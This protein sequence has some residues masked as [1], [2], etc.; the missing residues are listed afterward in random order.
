MVVYI[1]EKSW[2]AWSAMKI[3][4]GRQ[5]AIVFNKTIHLCNTTKPD[6]LNNR[7]WLLHELAHVHQYQELGFVNF[8]LRYLW[9]SAKNGYYNNRFEKRARSMENSDELLNGI[10]IL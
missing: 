4:G 6:F 7:S 10:E 5:L 8:L 2:I 1:K 3:T 9:E